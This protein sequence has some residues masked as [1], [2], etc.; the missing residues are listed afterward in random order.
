LVVPKDLSKIMRG[1]GKSVSGKRKK[2]LNFYEIKIKK[3]GRLGEDSG[4]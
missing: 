1:A 4:S 3:N 2:A